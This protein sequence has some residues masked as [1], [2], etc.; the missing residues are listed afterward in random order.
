MGT[1]RRR[2]CAAP[3]LAKFFVD[4]HRHDHLLLLRGWVQQLAC[5]MRSVSAALIR[6]LSD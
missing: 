3:H 5:Q 6:I 4:G 1:I 2:V